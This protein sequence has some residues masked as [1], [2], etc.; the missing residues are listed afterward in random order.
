M[1][2]NPV[3]LVFDIQLVEA[4]RRKAWVHDVHLELCAASTRCHSPG[5]ASPRH[6]AAA[7]FFA[8]K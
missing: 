7:A 1:S 3:L 2:G 5:T 4:A 6:E 8:S